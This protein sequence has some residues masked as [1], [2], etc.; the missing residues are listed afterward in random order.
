MNKVVPQAELRDAALK[1]AR[2]LADNAPMVLSLLREFV[3]DVIPRGPSEHVARGRLA[4]QRVRR[5]DD[6][7]EGVASFKE[8]RKPR[9]RGR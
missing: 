5:S 2:R 3:R 6:A 4:I 9:F 7:G 1:Y 8:K